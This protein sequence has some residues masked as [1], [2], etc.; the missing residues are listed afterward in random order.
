MKSL[1]ALGL[2]AIFLFGSVAT[3]E[4]VMSGPKVGTGIAAF[5]VTKLCGA[6]SDGIK[7]GN[8]LCYRCRNGARPQVM[9]FTR[10]TDAKVADLVNK[11]DK[12]IMS[13][14][15]SQL[16]VFVN[17]MGCLLYTSPSPRDATLSRMPSSA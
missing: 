3:A 11:L 14:S 1:Y 13:N 7:A 9:V 16:R 10:S 15:D 17:F 2:A 5:N 4:E 6:E 12:A 8:N